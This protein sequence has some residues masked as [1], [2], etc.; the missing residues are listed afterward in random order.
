MQRF[1]GVI[2][3]F[4]KNF[5]NSFEKII[6]LKSFHEKN[7]TKAVIETSFRKFRETKNQNNSM[8]L[9]LQGLLDWKS[10]KYR[11]RCRF[12]GKTVT[13]NFF[14]LAKLV[15]FFSEF[16]L[17]SYQMIFLLVQ[18]YMVFNQKCTSITEWQFHDF[19][20]T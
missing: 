10:C 5:V 2:L 18:A 7:W 8:N 16:L 4:T 1:Y 17:R 13:L 14:C 20:V 11:R 12:D 3:G 9:Q 6:F 15:I 19:S